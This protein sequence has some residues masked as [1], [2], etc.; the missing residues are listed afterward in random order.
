MNYNEAL[1]KIEDF[2]VKSNIR[3]FCTQVCHGKCCSGCYE[4]K[5]ACHLHEGRR[6]TCSAFICL[7][8]KS[9]IFNDKE[10]SIYSDISSKIVREMTRVRPGGISGANVYFYPHTKKER[11]EFHI[12]KGVLDQ[13]NKID[14][15]EVANKIKCIRALTER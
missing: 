9:L 12:D 3:K 14:I 5:N 8:L 15:D 7:N 4:S 1:E 13:L 2:M 11:K 6:L 10:R